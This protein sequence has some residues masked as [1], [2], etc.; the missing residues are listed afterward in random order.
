MK[1]KRLKVMPMNNPSERAQHG[2]PVSATDYC[3]QH[4]NGNRSGD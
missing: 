1:V 2:N 4:K 3:H